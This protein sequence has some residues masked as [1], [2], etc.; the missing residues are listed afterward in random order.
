MK[1][2]RIEICI[3]KIGLEGEVEDY[4]QSKTIYVSEK[5]YEEF[6]N[7]IDQITG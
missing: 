7:K 2:F 5:I 6:E 1:R 4:L 3:E